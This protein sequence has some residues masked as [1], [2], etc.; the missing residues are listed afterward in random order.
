MSPKSVDLTIRFESRDQLLDFASWLCD[1][2]EQSYWETLEGSPNRVTFDYFDPEDTT[3]AF[4]A[5][6]I[7]RTRP[8]PEEDG[9]NGEIPIPVYGCPPPPDDSFSAGP[10]YGCPPPFD[11]PGYVDVVSMGKYGDIVCTGKKEGYPLKETL[12]SLRELFPNKGLTD[13]MSQKTQVVSTDG[14]RRLLESY[15]MLHP[16]LMFEL[17]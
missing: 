17:V 6:G 14:S 13:L 2:G 15:R 9:N 16:S 10:A 11:Y 12:Q 7:I 5:D 1:C 3:R 8:Y 4:V